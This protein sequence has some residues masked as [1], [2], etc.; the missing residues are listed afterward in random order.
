MKLSTVPWEETCK[1]SR[2]YATTA[3][4][5]I[6]TLRQPQEKP[7]RFIY[8][9]GH[10]APRSR[11]EIPP[12]L[13]N[14]GLVDYGLLRGETETLIL[15]YAEQ[16]QGTVQSCIVKPGLIDAPGAEKREI[17]GLP[18]IDLPDIAAALL[19]QVIRGFEKDTLSNDDLVRIGQRALAG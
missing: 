14:H 12:A 5:T 17:P 4:K 7:L 15:D 18:H 8:M 1:I 2:D 6:H 3:I 10:F 13:Q 16:S 11:A 9:S 19:D